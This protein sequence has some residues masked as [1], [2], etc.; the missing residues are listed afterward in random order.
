M[1]G[2]VLAPE[3]AHIEAALVR[4]AGY[5]AAPLP[6]RERCSALRAAADELLSRTDLIARLLVDEIAKPVALARSEVE[7]SAE[8]IAWSASEWETMRT[9]VV[10]TRAAAGGEGHLV[11]TRRVPL[12][13]V[14][15]ITPFNFPVGLTVHKL[16][17]ALAAG[18]ACIIKPSEYAPRSVQAVADAFLAA[19]FPAGAV[20]VVPGGP[21]TVDALLASPQPGLY[22]FTGSA[23][24]GQKIKAESG[25]RPVVL[26]LGSN[27]ATIVH[28]DADLPRAA[29][30]LAR[31]A[32]SFAGQACFSVQRILVHR[33]VA[34]ELVNRLLEEIGALVVGDPEDPATTV[35]PM[36][37]EA[38]AVRVE[39]LIQD[40]VDRGAR[41]LAGGTRTDALLQ[42]TLV[43]DVTHDA[44]LWNEEAFGPVAIVETYDTA[45]E[46]FTRANDSR[47]GLQSGVFTSSVDFALTAL[48]SLHAGGV[49][50]NETSSWRCTP[51]P[52]GG[53]GESGFGREGPRHA[54]EAM[55]L[56]KTAVMSA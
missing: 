55:T 2:A 43:T 22:S 47:Y 17:P 41:V 28:S 13:I 50:V 16:A 33:D 19:G 53:I 12:G 42:P 49:L 11:Y 6:D 45:D 40:A 35:G 21:E 4:C 5:A 32:F 36:I 30:A 25:L 7:R 44:Q 51:M 27:A 37:S 48:D 15:A 14:C 54:L 56:L 39:D 20:E 3:Q 10:P 24:V 52:F 31:G 18:N 1:T 8:V 23:R 38:A 46:A 9:E 29:A 26:E 34:A